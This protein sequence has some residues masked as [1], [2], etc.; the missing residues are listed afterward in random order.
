[1]K[2][3]NGWT[4]TLCLYMIKTA[5]SEAKHAAVRKYRSFEDENMYYFNIYDALLC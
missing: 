3:V 1:M 2:N 5:V 4:T